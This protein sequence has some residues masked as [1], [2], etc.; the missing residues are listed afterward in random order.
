MTKADR[1]EPSHPAPPRGARA[2][3]P[4]LEPCSLQGW[5]VSR[6]VIPLVFML[7]L[8]AAM[9]LRRDRARGPALPPPWVKR[10]FSVSD[11]TADATRLFRLRPRDRVSTGR[12]LYLHGG[13]YMFDLIPAQW[14][15]IAELCRQSGAEVL[16]PLYPL[17]PEATVEQGLAAVSA[18][19][20]RAVSEVGAHRVILSG[21][22]AGG[23]LALVWAQHLRD[24]GKPPAAGLVLFSPWLDATVSGKDQ[25]RLERRDAMLSIDRL[26]Q[27]GQLWAG[28]RKADHPWVSPLFGELSDLP[29]IQVFA[30]TRDLLYSDALR[31]AARL[32][33][34]DLRRYDQMFHVW[35]P[36]PIPEA[37]HALQAAG[38]FIAARLGLGR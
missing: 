33:D 23:G 28:S 17:A 20:D 18:T 9:R 29:P 10:D 19:W 38:R 7:R 2:T 12:V 32:P 25:P 22:S 6:I 37:R 5:L 35:P 13:G 24:C 11:E 1:Q 21:D 30:G 8:P 14:T 15:I 26:R 3:I 4:E 36:A 34:I 27:A 31:L 16:V